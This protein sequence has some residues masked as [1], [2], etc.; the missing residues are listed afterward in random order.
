MIYF[1][2]K[3]EKFN[4]K[5]EEVKKLTQRPTNEELLSL[6]ALYKQATVGDN[7]TSKPWAVQLEASAKWNAWNNLKGLTF[8]LYIIFILYI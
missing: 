4:L 5:A 6:Y 3:E 7:N 8:N 1:Y 2:L